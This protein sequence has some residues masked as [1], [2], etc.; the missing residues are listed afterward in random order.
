MADFIKISTSLST[1][2]ALID[3]ITVTGNLVRL[4]VGSRSYDLSMVN[5]GET[6]ETVAARLVRAQKDPRVT[7]TIQEIFES[8]LYEGDLRNG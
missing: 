8:A 6:V 4:H 2:L 5:P 7:M 1:R 3:T